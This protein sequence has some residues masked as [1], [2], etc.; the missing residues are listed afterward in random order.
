MPRWWV[1]SDMFSTMSKDGV[2]AR[3]E[4][5]CFACRSQPRSSW[6]PRGWAPGL[7]L[8]DRFHD[9]FDLSALALQKVDG[10]LHVTLRAGE[11]HGHDADGLTGARL[12]DV[13]G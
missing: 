13:E 10:A 7:S 4:S 11:Q 6:P 1:S 8:D 2:N 12:A 9:R 3:P 5:S